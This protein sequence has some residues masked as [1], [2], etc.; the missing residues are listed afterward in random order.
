[1]ENLE[2][3]AFVGDQL[4]HNVDPIKQ[5]MQEYIANLIISLFFSERT[6]TSLLKTTAPTKRVLNWRGSRVW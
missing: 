3:I 4:K 5:I 6:S 1:M 2:P